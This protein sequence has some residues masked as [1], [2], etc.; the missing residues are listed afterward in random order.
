VVRAKHRK[1]MVILLH[2]IHRLEQFSRIIFQNHIRPKQKK[3][4]KKKKKAQNR[5]DFQGGMKLKRKE[6]S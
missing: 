4:D 2:Q 1:V 6:E 5:L 3:E